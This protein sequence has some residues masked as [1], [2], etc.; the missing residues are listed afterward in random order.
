MKRGR[1]VSPAMA[2]RPTTALPHCVSRAWLT[3]WSI[4]TRAGCSECRISLIEAK[5]RII[6]QR[7]TFCDEVETRP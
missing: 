1:R 3:L 5:P 4:E 7:T 2:A 6:T